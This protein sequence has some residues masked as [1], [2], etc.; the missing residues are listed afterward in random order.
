M[1]IL[2]VGLQVALATGALRTLLIG[3]FDIERQEI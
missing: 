3:I 1:N 2:T